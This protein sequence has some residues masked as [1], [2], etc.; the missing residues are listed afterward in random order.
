MLPPEPWGPD[1]WKDWTRAVADATGA[2]GRALFHPL[3]LA[4]TGEDQGPEMAALLPLLGQARTA[5]RLQ[6][7]AV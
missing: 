6:R 3:R 4:L 5:A 1:T 7:A 2:K